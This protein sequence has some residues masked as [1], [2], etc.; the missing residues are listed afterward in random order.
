MIRVVRVTTMI[1]RQTQTHINAVAVAA[2]MHDGWV[3]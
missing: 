1:V 3:D 2:A